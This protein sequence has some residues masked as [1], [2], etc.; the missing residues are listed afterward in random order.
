MKNPDERRRFARVVALL[1]R[2]QAQ[3]LLSVE[4]AA[5]T[6][7]DL[8]AFWYRFTDAEQEGIVAQWRRVARRATARD[9]TEA[10]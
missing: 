6:A 4:D 10:K 9:R 5:R 2:I 1:D 3:G 8:Q 7:N